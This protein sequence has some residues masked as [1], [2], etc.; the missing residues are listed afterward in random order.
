MVRNSNRPTYYA[1]VESCVEN[2]LSKVGKNIVLGIPIGLGKPNQLVNEFFR[3]ATK[4]PTLR[5]KIFTALTLTKPQWK[6]GLE[7]RLVEPLSAR[8]FGNYPELDYISALERS[9]LPPNIEVAEFYFQPGQLLHNSHAQQ[10][11]VSSNYTHVVRDSLDSDM[12]VFAQLISSAKQWENKTYYSLSCNADLT[13]DLIPKMRGL[14]KSGKKIAILGQ[15]N[16]ELPFMYGDAQVPS[17]NFDAIV[18]H[19]QYAFKLFGPPNMAINPSDYMIGLHASALIKDGGTIQ[20]GIGSLSDAVTYLIKMR[21]QYNAVYCALLSEANVLGKFEKMIH[22]VG[23]NEPFKEGLYA[24][25]EMFVD[26]F[27]QLYRSGILKRKVYP[28]ET[29]QR[30]LNENKLSHQI[31]P[32]ALTRLIEEKIIHP[33]LSEKEVTLLQQWGIFK[34]ELKYQNGFIYPPNEIPIPADLADSQ[35]AEKIY[36]HCLEPH[37]KGGHLLHA[38]FF[39]GPQRFYNFLR[40]LKKEEREQFCMKRVAYVNQLYGS[41][42]L[43]RL[44]RK[45]ARFLNSA[46]MV[47][48]N[49]AIISDKLEDGRTVSGV[50]GQ[51]NFVAMAHA[52]VDARSIIMLRSVREKHGEIHSN[53]IWNYGHTTIPCHLRDMVVTEYGIANLRGK[54]DREI[55]IALLNITDSRFQDFLL[56]EAQKAGKI[57]KN[58]QIPDDFKDNYPARLKKHLRPYKDQGYLPEFPFGTEFTPEEIALTKAFEAIQTMIAKKRFPIPNKHQLRAILSA[59]EI[60]TPYLQR[61]QLDKPTTMKDKL[62]QKLVLYGLSQ[63]GA[64]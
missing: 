44:Q 25:S 29:L 21:H 57:S 18:D 63:T 35:S 33:Q 30:L 20:L 22:N 47:T 53:I 27:M 24:T 55:I 19:P 28:H 41:E 3:R 31:S 62:M 50:G 14:E 4:D 36:R 56:R 38:S 54:N 40:G 43:K 59:P 58:Y 16:P 61:L 11:Y 1:D 51:Y 2:I 9:Q 15:I 45:D 48:L 49:G 6:N 7:R 64:M 39:L 26:G 32:A 42:E 10:N 17:E 23:G 52:L 5:L 60:A 34:M 12:N 8:I 13:P 37:I 46:L